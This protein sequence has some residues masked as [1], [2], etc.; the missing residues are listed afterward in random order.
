MTDYAVQAEHLTVTRRGVVVLRDLTFR[1]ALG[2]VHGLV[3]PSGCGKTTLMRALAG[4]QRYGGDLEVLSHPAGDPA[5]RQLIGYAAQTAAIYQ[6]LS[7]EDN[8]R[9][10]A[11]VVGTDHGEARRIL[12]Q[13]DLTDLRTRLVRHLSGGQRTRVSLGIALLGQPQLLVLDEPTVGLDPELRE[14]LWQLFRRLA[15]GGTTV[16]VSSHVM[17]EAERC[18]NVVVLRAGELLTQ[19]SPAELEKTTGTSGMN[20]AFLALVRH[21]AGAPR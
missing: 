17:D 21:G 10:F 2:R 7:V 15:D 11:H 12:Q 20:D 18:D 5:L 3:G 6:D 13:V 4:V 16:L 14:Q 8:L 1:A 19:G 9:Y